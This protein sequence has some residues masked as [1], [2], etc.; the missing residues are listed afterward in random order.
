MYSQA[1]LSSLKWSQI[2][3]YEAQEAIIFLGDH[4][5]R[6]L[7]E[8]LTPLHCHTHSI[9]TYNT[10]PVSIHL[11]CMQPCIARVKAFFPILLFLFLLI[12]YYW[13]LASKYP[14]LIGKETRC[15]HEDTDSGTYGWL[16]EEQQPQVGKSS[17]TFFHASTDAL[18]ACS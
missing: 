1:C 14:S 13:Y 12:S 5:T 4:T 7:A 8:I 17:S 10:S 11:F 3:P 9:V 2:P 6:P 18:Q 16:T 15:Q